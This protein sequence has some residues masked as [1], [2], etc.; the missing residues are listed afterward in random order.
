MNHTLKTDSKHFQAVLSGLKKFEYRLNDR[1]YELGD[2]L[3]L[4]EIDEN[5]L[6][7]GRSCKVHV[8]YILKKGYGLPDGYC[9][10]SITTPR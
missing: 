9:I 6:Y 2:Q 8:S 3:T 7:T 4:N 5:K 10:M 1:G